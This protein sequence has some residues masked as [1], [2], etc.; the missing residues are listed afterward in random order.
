MALCPRH[1][2]L[3]CLFLFASYQTLSE[4]IL[5]IHVFLIHPLLAWNVDSLRK[6]L[7]PMATSLPGTVP[8]TW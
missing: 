8:A 5:L 4:I 6:S 2:L 1:S 7:G 3:Y